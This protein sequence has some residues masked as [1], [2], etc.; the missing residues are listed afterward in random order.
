MLE[1]KPIIPLGMD[2]KTIVAITMAS[3][4]PSSDM[5]RAGGMVMLFQMTS[6][7]ARP[8]YLGFRA[9][10]LLEATFWHAF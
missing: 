2:Q 5:R 6:L 4:V 3:A 9:N 1:I 8:V 7:G 10:R